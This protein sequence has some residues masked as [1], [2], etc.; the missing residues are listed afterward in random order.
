MRALPDWNAP[1]GWRAVAQEEIDHVIKVKKALI[2]RDHAAFCAARALYPDTHEVLNAVIVATQ[3]R[4]ANGDETHK[5]IRITVADVKDKPGSKFLGD[6]Y[7]GAVDDTFVRFVAN[8]TL[9]RP[10]GRRQV[11][12]V[13]GAYYEVVT[14]P[15]SAGGRSLWIPVPAGWEDLGYPERT[16]GK[17]NFFEVVGNTPGLRDAGRE[18][19]K[20]YDAFLFEHGF[21]QPIVERRLFYRHSPT[22]LAIICVYV[23]D[24]WTYLDDVDESEIFY[25]LWSKRFNESKNVAS[26]G[27]D[28]CGVSYDDGPG[29]TLHL[30]CEKLLLAL[31]DMLVPFP[32]AAACASPMNGT[33]SHVYELSRQPKTPHLDQTWSRYRAPFLDLGCT[34]CAE[35]ALTVFS[36]LRP[37]LRLSS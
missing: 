17:R 18:F 36:P 33:C 26:A 12:D 21:Q 28:F 1:G 15:A 25:K 22:G 24:N 34:S 4:R 13:K 29:G 27:N 5:K 19:A 31:S 32:V 3:R 10:N 35:R 6:V 9:G 7:S 20:I 11:L 30:S 14:V 37:S 8:A 2:L 23:D 16:N